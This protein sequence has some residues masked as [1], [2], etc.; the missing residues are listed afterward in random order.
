MDIRVSQYLSACKDI[1]IAVLSK[2]GVYFFFLIAK[3]TDR[4]WHRSKPAIVR[5]IVARIAENRDS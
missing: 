5:K 2:T 4:K 1:L 3:E